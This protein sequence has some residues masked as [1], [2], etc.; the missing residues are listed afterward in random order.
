MRNK[1]SGIAGCQNVLNV[2]NVGNMVV[3]STSCSSEKPT[4]RS[5]LSID[6]GLS[7]ARDPYVDHITHIRVGESIGRLGRRPE[8]SPFRHQ[9]LDLQVND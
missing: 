6:R 2:L 8:L 3:I 9:K 1:Q 7:Q 5:R 4:R